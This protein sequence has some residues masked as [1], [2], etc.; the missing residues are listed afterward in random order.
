[1]ADSLHVPEIASTG[2]AGER[3]RPLT[4]IG[5]LVYLALGTYF[6]VVVT[7]GELVSWFRIQEMFRFVR[8]LR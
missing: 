4:G 1:M 8:Q 5:I 2:Y 7:K 6:G 3:A